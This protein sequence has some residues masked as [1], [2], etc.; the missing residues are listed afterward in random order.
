MVE[1][2]KANGD[3]VHCHKRVNV[4]TKKKSKLKPEMTPP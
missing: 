2:S 4:N 1:I 3:F